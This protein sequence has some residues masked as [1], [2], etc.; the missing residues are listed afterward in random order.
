MRFCVTC[1]A[2]GQGAPAVSQ[3]V[4]LS[5][6]TIG[7]YVDGWTGLPLCFTPVDFIVLGTLYIVWM[8][9]DDGRA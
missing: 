1:A 6:A 2:I 4:V 5:A 7:T 8:T 9:A 3:R